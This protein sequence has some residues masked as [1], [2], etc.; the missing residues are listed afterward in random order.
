MHTVVGVSFKEAGKIYYFDPQ[1]LELHEGDTVIV[2]TASGLES[3]HVVTGVKHVS[4]EEVTT[5][6]KRVVRRADERDIKHLEENRQKERQALDICQAKVEE[7]GLAMKLVEAEYTF[8]RS[9]VVFYFTADGRVDFR[10]LVRRLASTLKTRIEMHQIGVRDE[11]KMIGGL[12]MCGRSL[13]CATFLEGFQPVSIKMAKE[14]NLPL[15]PTKIS[16]M[17]G[18]LMCCLNY[19]N[20]YY[21]EVK[22]RLPKVGTQVETEHGAGTIVE[23]NVPKESVVVRLFEA[24][25]VEVPADSV[26]CGQCNGQCKKGKP[27][28]N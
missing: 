13:C 21:K 17:C 1:E 28:K 20:D 14:Q 22:S 6:L 12:G 27:V 7:L 26:K 23:V 16:G 18:R 4:P 11:A 10:E 2:E 25:H 24:G 5:P 3:G 19:E 15:N 8:D 9:R